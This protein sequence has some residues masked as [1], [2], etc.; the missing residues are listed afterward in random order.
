METDAA[1]IVFVCEHGSAKSLMAALFCE[2]LAKDRGLAVRAVSRATVPDA[3]VPPS[4]VE[5]LRGDGFDVASFE[6][7]ALSAGD[8]RTA[9]WVVAIGVDVG[10]GKARA[11]SRLERWDDIP[12]LSESYP[13][14]R[15][16]IVSRLAS[17]LR[18]LEM[19][20]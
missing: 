3:I 17:L 16:A 10:D 19:H 1:L 6:P 14:A 20:P 15:Q 18:R 13:M 8:L 5:S 7:R 9:A 4:V 2:R 11:G 12:P